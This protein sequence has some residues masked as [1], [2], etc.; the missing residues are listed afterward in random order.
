MRVSHLWNLSMNNAC[1][2]V[3]LLMTPKLPECN[4]IPAYLSG[5][6]G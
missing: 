1:Q 4:G 2:A 3:E 6:H 5:K